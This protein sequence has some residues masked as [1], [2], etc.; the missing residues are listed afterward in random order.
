M[1]HFDRATKI[2]AT[3]G[4]ASRNPETLE[5]MIDAGLNVVRMNFSHGD[6]EDHR[7][8][9]DMVRA[10][11]K[12]KG[13][14]IGIL[15]DLQGPKI[16]VGR[17]KDGPVTL[18]AGQPFIITMD[19]VEGTAERVSSTY[20]GLA[21]DVR[22]GMALLLDDGNMALEVTKVQGHDVHTVVTVG[23]VLKNN[24]GINVP[25]ADLTV[26]AL[27]DKDVEDLTFGAELGVDWVA[28]SFVRSRDD[29]LLA[30]HYLARAGSRAK[31]MAKI[32]KP[33]AVERFD[34]IL[35][36]CDGV[37]VARGD[38]GVEMRPEQV[39]IIQKRLIRACREAGKPVIT[40]TQMLESMINL[41][42]PTRAEASDVANAIFDGTDAVML[43][44][45][46]AAGLYPVE[47][48]SM[49]DHIAREAEASAEY[50]IMQAQEIDTTLAQDAIA[51]AACNIGERMDLAAI[52]TFTKTGGAA[53]RVAKNRPKLPILALTPNEQTRSQLAL[54]WG[55][56]PI[57]SEDPHDTD[58]MVRIANNTLRDSRLAAVGERYVITAGVPFGVAGSTN[59]LR[60]EKLRQ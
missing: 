19:D 37:M 48:V 55:I 41:P 7:Q 1:K 52:V 18:S 4:P 11:A 58:D 20:K 44:A 10:L 34:D 31:L 28:L 14:S 47:A 30:R 21:L 42:R 54:S 39:P 57:L 2:V 45:E 17:F 40:A 22:P 12:K 8:T 51:Q 59:M 60:V 13:V 5:R 43:S 15:Q 33:Q 16:R 38:L 35:K 9:Y 27:S 3:I 24:K 32:E 25:E 23:G 29:L 36:E 49:M 26:P 53:T 50:K 56:V 6:Q 46:S